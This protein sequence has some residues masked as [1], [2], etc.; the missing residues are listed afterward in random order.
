MLPK[1]KYYLKLSK[2]SDLKSPKERRIYRAFEILPGALAWLTLLGVIFLSGLKPIWVAIF[3]I[4]FDVYWLLKTIYLSFHLRSGY[5]RMKKQMAIDWIEKLKLLKQRSPKKNWQ[6]IYHL[7][8]LPF[9]KE[10]L[11]VIQACFQAIIDSDYPKDKM[12]IVL[13]TEE[14]VGQTGERTAQAIKKE[15]ADRFY[16]FLITI[17]PQEIAG[18]LA[19][20][21]SN[22]TWAA[23]Q[24]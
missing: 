23:R 8:I 17:H 19:G 4:I 20:K 24:V 11:S 2:A 12:I 18:E 3:I 9:Y 10:P 21:G 16:K 14:R 13:A 5:L 22:S 15:F 1:D 7:I 6:N